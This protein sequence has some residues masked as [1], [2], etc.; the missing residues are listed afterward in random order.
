MQINVKK[1]TGKWHMHAMQTWGEHE[2]RNTPITIPDFRSFI[3]DEKH[4]T[5]S[6]LRR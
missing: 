6:R 5:R 3:T 4:A 1:E 2:I